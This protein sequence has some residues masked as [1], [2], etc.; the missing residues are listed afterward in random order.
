M[1]K[2]VAPVRRRPGMTHNEFCRY[3]ET[4][5]GGLVRANPTG[6]SRYVQNHIFDSAY[7]ADG[8][9]G[10]AIVTPRDSVTELYFKDVAALMETFASPYTREVIGPDGKKFADESTTLNMLVSDREIPVSAKVET[11]IKVMH[12][13]ATGPRPATDFADDWATFHVASQTAP[14]ME[15]VG[16]CVFSLPVT[17][18]PVDTLAAYFGGKGGPSYCGVASYWLRG[19]ADIPLFRDYQR[20]LESAGKAQG[21]I[22]PSASFVVFAREIS[23]VDFTGTT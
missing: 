3:I 7:G 10:Y 1:I 6:L 14:L 4:V 9:D 18:G 12:F 5:H 13:L 23:I 21:V 8:D 2:I 20:K 11:Q 17:G 16:R 15:S 19:E 22:D